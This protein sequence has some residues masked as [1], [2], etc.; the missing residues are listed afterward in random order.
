LSIVRVYPNSITDNFYFLQHKT[1]PF[2]HSNFTPEYKRYL[3]HFQHLGATF[4]VTFRLADSLPKLF[5]DK[6]TAQYALTKAKIEQ[7]DVS[8]PEKKIQI[9]ILQRSYFIEYDQA[10]DKCYN[11]PVWLKEPLVAKH[12]IEQLQRYDG[13]YYRL[14]G[15][16]IMPNHVHTLLD[17]SIQLPPEQESGVPSNYRNLSAVIDLVKGASARLANLTL[18]RTGS[19][20]WQAGYHDRYIRDARHLTGAINYLKQ[21]PVSAGLCKHWM[22]HPFTWVDR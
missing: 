16:T 2:M 20:F 5:L 9:E 4:F 10:L 18:K 11:G 7:S 17:F 14:I 1:L 3:P 15:F 12:V 22:E 19:K 8:A 13:Q 21:N 6:T